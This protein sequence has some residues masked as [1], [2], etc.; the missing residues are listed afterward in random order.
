[1]K[2]KPLALGLAIGAFWAAMMFLTTWVSI[3]TGYAKQ[4]LEIFTEIY[5]GYSVTPLGSLLVLPYGFVDGFVFGAGVGW[6]YNR[7][8]K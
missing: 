8:S 5:P 6:L 1:M 3:Y 7:F 2:L 4:F